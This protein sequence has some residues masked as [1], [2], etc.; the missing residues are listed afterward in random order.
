MK[1]SISNLSQK[2]LEKNPEKTS[3]TINIFVF[4]FCRNTLINEKEL[5]KQ[6]FI[7]MIYIVPA[8]VVP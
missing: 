4:V 6:K 1:S 8:E 3:R 5:S 7:K 2:F